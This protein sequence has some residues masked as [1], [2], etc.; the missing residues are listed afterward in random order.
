MSRP[1]HAA[2]LRRQRRLGRV[3]G[4]GRRAGVPVGVRR[5]RVPA[6]RGHGGGRARGG[7]RGRG[8]A[9]DRGRRRPCWCRR[10]TSTALAER[11]R[12]GAG[13]RRPPGR[14][15]RQG[16][17]PGGAIHLG[18]VRRGPG[19]ALRRRGRGA[20]RTRGAAVDDAAG[21]PRR[22]A[23]RGRTAA[24]PG[25]GRDRDLRAGLLGGLAT[26]D[27]DRCRRPAGHA[28]R[29]SARGRVGRCPDPLEAFGRP[30]IASRLPGPLLTRLW[31][32]ALV[33]APEGFDLVHAVS[34]AVPPVQR[35]PTGRRCRRGRRHPRRGVAAPARGLSEPGPA[36]ARGRAADGPCARRRISWC[37]PKPSPAISSTAGAPPGGGVGD[38]ARVRRPARPRRRRGRGRCSNASGCGASSCCRW[39]RSSRARTCLGC[40]RPTAPP[41]AVAARALAAGGGRTARVGSGARTRGGHRVHRS[42][43]VM[44]PWR[45]C[46]HGPGCSPTCP[47]EEG[48]GLPPVEAMRYGTPV[49]SSPLPDHRRCRARGRPHP[50]RRHRPGPGG[51]WPPTRRS[52]RGWP[53]PARRAPTASRGSQ[54]LAPTSRC[55]ARCC[56]RSRCAHG[57]RRG[58]VGLGST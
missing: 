16:T 34:V 44:A 43:R 10:A 36:V 38:P 56:E 24:A 50:R 31:D 42:G 8:G 55:G 23:S 28:L 9:R 41:A 4:G 53:R 33:H 5:I 7:E 35:S 26:L 20:R 52:G 19:R 30:V 18:G 25:A 3:A 13:R 49:V 22:R 17:V 40:S 57:V 46:T 15:H 2:G 39:G 6:P 21:W 14:A 1:G 48:F 54:R 47:F 51:R 29:E 37:P 45:R 11:A 27:D 32:R 12:L 58:R